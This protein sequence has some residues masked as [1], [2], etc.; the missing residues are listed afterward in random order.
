VF[1]EEPYDRQLRKIGL[2]PGDIEQEKLPLWPENW[3]VVRLFALLQGQWSFRAN[4]KL[5]SIRFEAI[6]RD[7][8]RSCGIKRRER[9]DALR[10]LQEMIRAALDHLYPDA[11]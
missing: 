8:W 2:E 10:D 9:T 6:T 5:Q 7:V 3:S 11:Q 1:C 4:G